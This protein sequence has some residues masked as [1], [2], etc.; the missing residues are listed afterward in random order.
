MSLNSRH[1]RTAVEAILKNWTALQLAV[2]QHA[3][4]GHS[5]AVA[6]WMVDAVLQW[7]SE[8]KDLQPFEV[9][10]FLEDILNQEFNVIIEDGSSDE[11]G[12]FICEFFSLCLTKS[13]EEV[14]ARLRTLPKCDLAACRVESDEQGT[15]AN[16]A[17]LAGNLEDMDLDVEPTKKQPEVDPEGWQVITRKKK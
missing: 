13:E 6:N 4:G 11:I 10:E 16:Q 14:V 1:F 7:F 9:S 12:T 5:A 8:N 17:E 2:S 3:A 15:E